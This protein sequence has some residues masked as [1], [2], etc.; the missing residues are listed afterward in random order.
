[1]Q[2]GQTTDDASEARA[3]VERPVDQHH[4]G[5]AVGSRPRM[6]HHMETGPV[7]GH[8]RGRWPAGS[9]RPTGLKVARLSA[10]GDAGRAGSWS[11]VDIEGEGYRDGPGWTDLP[12]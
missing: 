9:T 12:R 10:W 7:S 5:G 1:V 6:V 2:V 11:K 8:R 3:P 4:E